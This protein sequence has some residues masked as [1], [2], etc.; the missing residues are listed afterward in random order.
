MFGHSFAA[1]HSAYVAQGSRLRFRA[2]KW[3]YGE[4]HG[5]NY[6][7]HDMKTWVTWDFTHFVFSADA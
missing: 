7:Q 6:M 1:M 5:P 2:L 4:S 3:D